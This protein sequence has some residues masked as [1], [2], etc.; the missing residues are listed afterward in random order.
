M[1]C[2]MHSIAISNVAV[3]R[4]QRA[5]HA[6]SAGVVRVRVHICARAKKFIFIIIILNIWCVVLCVVLCVVVC[7]V[8]ASETPCGRAF[9][10]VV[11]CVVGYVVGCVVRS[12]VVVNGR[13]C[14]AGVVVVGGRKVV[15]AVGRESGGGRLRSWAFGASWAVVGAKRRVCGRLRLSGGRWRS[16][17]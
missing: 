8:D 17:A 7:V 5:K 10:C 12:C 11:G 3:C 6:R 14:A 15:L 9:A 2:L 13:G 4:A 1:P 16:S